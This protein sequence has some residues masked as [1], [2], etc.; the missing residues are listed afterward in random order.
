MKNSSKYNKSEIMKQAWR[1]FKRLGDLTTFSECLSDA[2]AIAKQ[3]NETDYSHYT[4][5]EI[6]NQLDNHDFMFNTILEIVSEKGNGFKKDIAIKALKYNRLSEK[7]AWC[8]A[9]EFK[10]VA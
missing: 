3:G 9:Y 6:F 1:F 4:V 2:W 10:N 5:T 8:V 7:Q